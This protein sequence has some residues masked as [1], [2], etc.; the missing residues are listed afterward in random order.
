MT[1]VELYCNALRDKSNGVFGNLSITVKYVA[2]SYTHLDVYKRQ[3][4]SLA[5]TRYGT[6][7]IN[8]DILKYL[9][10]KE[11]NN[12]LCNYPPEEAR[13]LKCRRQ[14]LKGREYSRLAHR[15]RIE[16]IKILELTN[17]N[18]QSK[19]R[20]LEL[21]ANNLRQERDDLK[22]QN[23]HLIQGLSNLITNVNQVQT[24]GVYR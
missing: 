8:D 20:R 21:E 12:I 3:G 10:A 23:E 2:V 11:L 1:N 13:T 16:K 5:N 4:E 19:I 6:S 15:K 22:R 17:L 18:N 9:P 7:G 14:I 24:N